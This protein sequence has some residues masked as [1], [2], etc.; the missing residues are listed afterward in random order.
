MNLVLCL[1]QPAGERK[2]SMSAYVVSKNHILFLV[3]AA[4]SHRDFSWWDGQQH[5]RLR[6]GESEEAAKVANMLWK[7]NVK[8]VQYRY[9]GEDESTLPSDGDRRTVFIA[10]DFSGEGHLRRLIWESSP[11]RM[12]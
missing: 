7:E 9:R 8:S 6:D 1:L 3:M 11:S 4:M 10:S 12:R 2:V 5:H